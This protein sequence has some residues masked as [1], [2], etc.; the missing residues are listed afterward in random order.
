MSRSKSSKAKK[1]RG[2]LG[3][4]LFWGGIVLGL[5]ILASIWNMLSGPD[6]SSLP[7]TVALTPTSTVEAMPASPGESQ[8]L[9]Q[10]TD[11]QVPAPTVP[12]VATEPAPTVTPPIASIEDTSRANQAQIL[13][14]AVLS[15][16]NL[17]AGPGTD[18]AIVGAVTPGEP[19][20]ITG[21]SPD[22][23]WYALRA[24]QWIHRDLVANP[25][26]ASLLAI[27]APPA[28][29]T[30]APAPA[31]V[32][33]DQVQ[34]TVARVRQLPPSDC[35]CSGNIYNCSDFPAFEIEG[36]TAQA[37][38]L[39]CQAITGLDVHDLDRDSDG[40][41]CEWSGWD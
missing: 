4:I 19:L 17:R 21:I 14:P 18:T 26:D 25:P 40:S 37:C 24:G 22:G 2:C 35:D 27:V 9:A 38:F 1:Q 33:V 32:F 29:A 34:P 16:A 20:E 10:P 13:L 41:A 7:P 28:T 15:A 8:Q 6:S 39:R 12:P 31:P 30:P 5:I 23:Q 3:R 11:T 36:D